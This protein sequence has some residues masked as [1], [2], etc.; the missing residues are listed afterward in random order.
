VVEPHRVPLGDQLTNGILAGASGP[1]GVNLNAMELQIQAGLLAESKTVSKYGVIPNLSD[2]YVIWKNAGNSPRK[3]TRKVE[4]VFGVLNVEAISTLPR[5][6]WTD[7]YSELRRKYPEATLIGNVAEGC[8]DETCAEDEKAWK[9]TIELMIKA[10]AKVIVLNLSCP[11]GLS[12]QGRGAAIGQNKKYIAMCCRWAREVARKYGVMVFAKLTPGVGT[13]NIVEFADVVFKEDCGVAL[14]NT[15]PGNGGVNW[16]DENEP[17]MAATNGKTIPGGYGGPAIF[18]MSSEQV[19]LVCKLRDLH[20]KH[21]PVYAMGGIVSGDGMA[22]VVGYG[23]DIVGACW[24]FMQGEP[25]FDVAQGMLGRFREIVHRK[26]RTLENF[27][28]S[29][30]GDFGTYME[31]LQSKKKKD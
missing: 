3:F 18:S 27:R 7:T 24:I 4:D 17:A 25:V 20:Y 14:T 22:T 6:Y 1:E 16:E 8:S 21:L 28:G 29:R 23:A 30:Q 19:R 31:L 12:E 9:E 13:Y 5:E 2:L 26:G 15:W 11:Q 10:G